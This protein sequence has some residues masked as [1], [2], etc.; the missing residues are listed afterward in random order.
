MAF[1]TKVKE[2]NVLLDQL[3]VST[4]TSATRLIENVNEKLP[5]LLENVNA[6]AGKLLEHGNKYAG[7][8]I[9]NA[10]NIKIKVPKIDG[11][12]E[13]AILA[14]GAIVA[15]SAISLAY[16]LSAKRERKMKQPAQ[17]AAVAELSAEEE[18]EDEDEEKEEENKR[19]VIVDS[20]DKNEEKKE[21]QACIHYICTE[22]GQ[23]KSADE[24][25]K[26]K[27]RLAEDLTSLATSKDFRAQPPR[28]G[29]AR[30]L[31]PLNSSIASA[32]STSSPSMP[33]THKSK[34]N[35]SFLGPP[36]PNNSVSQPTSPVL[37]FRRS[38]SNSPHLGYHS[39][40]N[41]Q[42]STKKKNSGTNSNNTS[43]DS[44]NSSTGDD[45]NIN[46]TS[47]DNGSKL[48]RKPLTRRNIR[49]GLSV[50][51]SHPFDSNKVLLSVNT[52]QKT[53]V[54]QVPS[55][56]MKYGTCVM[57]ASRDGVLCSEPSICV[58]VQERFWRVNY[59][60]TVKI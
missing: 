6:N 38:R 28:R 17:K 43:T 36:S 59:R 22:C 1:K 24:K 16:Q 5:I 30:Y 52:A 18:D 35:N 26:E 7:R 10:K 49:L 20:T 23:K 12:P 29:R 44:I 33:P 11:V 37:D 53:P 9:E 41:S 54:L 50:V 32:T 13:S 55:G 56:F 57:R 39:I 58:C 21:E 8:L 42:N 47:T 14:G 31:K 27:E 40:R 34:H 45:S 46:N 25:E 19:E 15:V 60:A 48:I 51:M 3:F 2:V 4:S